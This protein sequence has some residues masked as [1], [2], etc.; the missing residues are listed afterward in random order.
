MTT[1]ITGFSPKG[2]DQY[3]AQ[4]LDSFDRYWPRDV[5]LLCFVEESTPGPIPR[6]AERSLWSCKGMREFIQRHGGHPRANGREPIPGRWSPKHVARGYYYK[7]DAVKFSRQCFIPEGAADELPDGEVMAWMDADVVTFKAIPPGFVEGLL[8]AHDLCYLGRN[9][10]H[11]ELGFWAV[12]LNPRTRR[13]LARL[14]DLFRSDAIFG[15]QEWHS[16]YAFDYTR[17]IEEA[18]AGEPIRALNLTPRGT[19]HVWFQSPLG[20]YTDHLKGDRR[21]AAGRSLE[22]AG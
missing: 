22:R 3:G 21:K 14:A 2:Y 7:F 20:R 5:R 6:G 1:I 13:I 8:G 11:T 16:A 12:R 9:G 4:F 18:L 15:L 10:M 19:G 17:K